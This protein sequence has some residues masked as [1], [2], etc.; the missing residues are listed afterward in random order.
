M[1]PVGTESD[2]SSTAS[3]PLNCLVTLVKE[4]AFDIVGCQLP[5][6]RFQLPGKIARDYQLPAFWGAGR[7]TKRA[8]N[9]E[10][11]TGS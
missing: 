3:V 7:R 5:A 6:A 10:L 2:K 1:D 9:W 11:E 8:G 4:M